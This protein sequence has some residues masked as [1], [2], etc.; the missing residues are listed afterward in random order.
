MSTPRRK[1]AVVAREAGVSV[2]T[3]S[4][5]LRAYPDVAPATR[6]RV[7]AVL[8]SAGYPVERTVRRSA[9]VLVD[10]VV[11][12]TGTSWAGEVLTGLAERVR[13]PGLAVVVTTVTPGSPVPRLWLEQLFTRGSRGVIG[14]DAEFT[15]VQLAY[16]AA[17]QI[18][19]VVVDSGPGD[20]VSHALAAILEIPAELAG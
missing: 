18:P 16:L 20:A 10:V 1:L 8:R 13:E 7:R 6:E 9:S 5:V 2:S 14:L 17:H 11:G 12:S 3:V 19:C 15:E 4:K